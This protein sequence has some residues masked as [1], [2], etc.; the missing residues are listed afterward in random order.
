M[1]KENLVTGMGRVRRQAPALPKAGEE[2][3]QREARQA[4]PHLASKRRALRRRFVPAGAEALVLIIEELCG[5]GTIS[6][7]SR[8][9]IDECCR[10]L[11]ARLTLF[12]GDRLVVGPSAPRWGR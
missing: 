4:A 7:K 2:P 1:V 12:P 8:P 11:S 10:L 5:S 3:G 6:S 9:T